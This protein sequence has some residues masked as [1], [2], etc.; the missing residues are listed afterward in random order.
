MKEGEPMMV[1]LYC[2]FVPTR[3]N[4]RRYKLDYEIKAILGDLIQRKRQDILQ[5]KEVD[6]LGLLL[7]KCKLLGD[8]AAHNDDNNCLIIDDVIEEC[9]LF[10]IAGQE[11]TANLL[12]WTM[13]VL[14]MHPDWQEKAREEVIRLCGKETPDFDAINHLKIVSYLLPLFYYF[15][16]KKLFITN[17]SK[18]HIHKFCNFETF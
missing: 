5:N 11:T 8:Q 10:Y 14:S 18:F 9:K 1:I 17:I 6:L 4:R 3:K 2:R 12:T 13:I 16:L 15:R 7:Q